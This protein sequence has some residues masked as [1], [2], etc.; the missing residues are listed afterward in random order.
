MN[1]KVRFSILALLCAALVAISGV[2]SCK[3]SN[4]ETTRLYL[5]GTLRVKGWQSYIGVGETFSVKI[6]GVSHPKQ[7]TQGH[8]LGFYYTISGVMEHPDTV[9]KTGVNPLPTPMDNV[10]VEINDFFGTDTLGT[11]TFVGA[12]YAEDYMDYYPSTITNYI[13]TVDVER[14]LP[15]ARVD[16]DRPYLCDERELEELDMCYNYVEADTLGNPYPL[17]WMQHNLAY[18]G[19][20]RGYYNF[21]IMSR[22]FGRYYTWEEAQTACPEGWRLPTDQDWAAF[23]NVVNPN[24][25][26]TPGKDFDNIAG[27][28]KV[29][30]SFNGKSMWEYWPES[31]ITSTST[32]HALPCGYCN[33]GAELEFKGIQ[34]F[35]CFW[36]ADSVNSSDA[37]Y[38]YI[39]TGDDD[40]KLGVGDKKTLAISVRC[41]S[42]R[43]D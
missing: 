33:A 22:M 34:E 36:T 29:D 15:Q 39:Y 31:M 11:F 23:A 10:P 43:K 42:D 32:F 13:T 27:T 40:L 18:L 7:D 4:S 35:A 19:S 26:Y 25:F 28:L 41:V 9:Y 38:R 12:V 37:Y 16:K 30:A 20:G 8:T 17:R 3:K 24:G 5:N 21:D 2:S 1:V 6:S 14:S